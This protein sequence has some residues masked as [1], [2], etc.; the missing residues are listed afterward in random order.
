[1]ERIAKKILRAPQDGLQQ[2][3]SRYSPLIGEVYAIENTETPTKMLF[4]LRP[5]GIVVKT[6]PQKANDVR[7]RHDYKSLWVRQ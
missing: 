5:H 3:I 4:P 7:H 1:M 6:E 2:L